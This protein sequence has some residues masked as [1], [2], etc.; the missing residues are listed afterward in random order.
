MALMCPHSAVLRTPCLFDSPKRT[1]CWDWK[2]KHAI[3][4]LSSVFSLRCHLR[5]FRS[6]SP[7]SFPLVEDLISIICSRGH[8]TGSCY[9]WN[10]LGCHVVTTVRGQRLCEDCHWQR[11]TVRE[12]DKMRWSKKNC[13]LCAW[14]VCPLPGAATC[15]GVVGTLR[16]PPSSSW[17]ARKRGDS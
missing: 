10:W 2:T 4:L 16:P 14:C 8:H 7:L 3:D 17:A 15:K 13:Y 6:C 5:L 12:S 11:Q 1:Q 9:H